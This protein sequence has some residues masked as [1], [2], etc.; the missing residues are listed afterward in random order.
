MAYRSEPEL[1]N[2]FGNLVRARFIE[3]LTRAKPL[4]LSPKTDQNKAEAKTQN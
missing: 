2:R 1:P 4:E 3:D